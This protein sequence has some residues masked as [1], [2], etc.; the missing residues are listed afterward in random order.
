MLVQINSFQYS[1]VISKPN[2]CYKAKGYVRYVDMLCDH[3]KYVDM[4]CDHAKCFIIS[5]PVV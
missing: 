2:G 1:F 5:V 3:A 4:L